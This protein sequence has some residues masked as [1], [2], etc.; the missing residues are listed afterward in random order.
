M[1]RCAVANDADSRLKK[2]EGLQQCANDEPSE[3]KRHLG[4]AKRS[5]HSCV[6]ALACITIGVAEGNQ[7]CFRA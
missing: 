4:Y 5:V 7:A 1:S 2:F 3:A 6:R